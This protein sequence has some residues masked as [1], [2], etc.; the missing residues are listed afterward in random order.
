[1]VYFK[2]IKKTEHYIAEHEREVPWHEVIEIILTTKNPR[3][4]GDRIEIKNGRYYVL[5]ELKD[6]VLWVINA[7]R[8]R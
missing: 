6:Q 1:L 3:K 2:D 7:K 4:K 5:C 8:R